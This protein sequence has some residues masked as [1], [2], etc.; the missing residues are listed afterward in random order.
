METRW[1]RDGDAMDDVRFLADALARAKSPV[2]LTGA[3]ISTEA[4][5]P[6]FRGP[7]G[8]YATRAY[9]EDVF[10]IDVFV[11]DPRGFYA[12]ARD[13]LA[14]RKGI[15]P[16]FAHEW[17]ARLESEG[18]LRGVVTQNIDGLH[19]RAGSRT[20]IEVHGGFEWS[21]C[22]SCGRRS[23]TAKIEAEVIAGGI[24]HCSGCA[25]LVKP[26]IVFFGEPVKGMEQAERLMR[27]SDLLLVVGSSL[28][29][30]PAAG[31][32]GVAG[33]QVVIVTRGPVSVS[34]RARRIDAD[35]DPFFRAV[36][37]ALADREH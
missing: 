19:Q 7:K 23:R 37:E 22:L 2:A 4:G 17:L 14:L 20:V 12:F 31:L 30:F 6:D 33:G 34:F 36:A 15:R 26:D 13:F 11:K 18:R 5:I 1:R 28:T 8:I 16:T 10:D 32:P 24:P 9:P 21:V 35:I 25:G 27:T 3:G 29:V